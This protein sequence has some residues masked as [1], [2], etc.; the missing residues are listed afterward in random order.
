MRMYLFDVCERIFA[1]GAPQT[2]ERY[3]ERLRQAR[4]AGAMLAVAREMV[5]EVEAVA[6]EQRARGL[7]ERIEALL[8]GERG[9]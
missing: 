5:E 8:P 4:E 1:R 6:G 3:R 9:G 7:R 2:A